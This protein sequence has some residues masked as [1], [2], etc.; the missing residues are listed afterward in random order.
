[1]NKKSQ[2][3]KI[4]S[5]AILDMKDN[6]RLN[7]FHGRKS[8]QNKQLCILPDTRQKPLGFKKLA[9]LFLVLVSG[10]FIS[11]L[12]VLF[13]FIAKMYSK[14]QNSTTTIE[15]NIEEFLDALSVDETE[16]VFQRILQ[17]HSRAPWV[18]N[19]HPL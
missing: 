9:F 13:E 4:F 1:M 10:I 3:T 16:K 11:I 14:K 19:A 2:F 5:Q 6:G 17:N 7:I 15:D 8:Q 12:V 18:K